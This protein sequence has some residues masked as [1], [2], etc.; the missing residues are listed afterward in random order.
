MINNSI[1]DVKIANLTNKLREFKVKYQ[2]DEE[3]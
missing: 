2:I 1:R 3:P